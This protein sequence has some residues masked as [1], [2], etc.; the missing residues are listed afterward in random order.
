MPFFRKKSVASEKRIVLPNV[1][2]QKLEAIVME[3]GPDREVH[4]TYDAG[5]LE[6]MTPLELHRRGDRLLESLLLVVADEAGETLTNLGSILLMDPES[7]RAIQP[8]GA[9]Y[10]DHLP[11]PITTRELNVTGIA[12]PDLAIELVIKPGT[13]NRLGIF[14]TLGVREVWAYTLEEEKDSFKGVLSL[15]EL[16]DRGYKSIGSSVAFPFLSIPRID[17]FIT[18]SETL[19]LSQA[20]TL[21]RSWVSEA[22]G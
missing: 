6:L 8:F 12:A 20:L 3:L 16:T 2:W 19:G 13:M 15:W 17:Q 11:R 4:L 14:E 21:L 10:L 22:L 18:E 5:K 7:D 9:Y 1:T